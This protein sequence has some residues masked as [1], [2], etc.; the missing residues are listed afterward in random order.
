MNNIIYLWKQTSSKVA[1]YSPQYG[2]YRFY[3]K[4][5]KTMIDCML[6]FH[7]CYI[8]RYTIYFKNHA[9]WIYYNDYDNQTTIINGDFYKKEGNSKFINEKL[10]HILPKWTNKI[11][12]MRI[13]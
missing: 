12:R 11:M 7:K 3:L 1:T 10:L 6:S 4:Y 13:K 2:T 5:E 8:N 9:F